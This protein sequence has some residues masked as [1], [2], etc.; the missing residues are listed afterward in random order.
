L[1]DVKL[2]KF[3]KQMK[4]L[5]RNLISLIKYPLDLILSIIVVPSAFLFLF[6]RRLGSA[7]LPNT[8]SR[9]RNIGV[10]PILDHY[11]EPLFNDKQ[12][13]QPLSTDRA[14]PGLNLNTNEQLKFLSELVYAE[15]LDLLNLNEPS[16]GQLDFC[17]NNGSFESGDAEF[18]YQFIRKNKPNKIIEIGSGNST[19]IARLA[20]ERNMKESSK[21]LHT[22]ALSLTN[23]H[24]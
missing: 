18:L 5:I 3:R 6:Y 1:A 15:E 11:Y 17:I 7:R 4:N 8:T 19:K 21:K 22:F 23:N 2:N 13:L 20:I 12:L 16:K 24:G 9:L 14:L 10:F